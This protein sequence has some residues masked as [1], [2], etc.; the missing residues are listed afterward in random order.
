MRAGAFEGSDAAGGSGWSNGWWN[1]LV[2]ADINGDGYPD[3]VAGNHGLNSRFRVSATKPVSM[4]VSDFD[5][6]GST[7]QIVCCY[8]GRRAIRWY[9][10]T[11]WWD[12][13]PT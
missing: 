12:S 13:Y 7:E 8:N 1:R 5:G 10:V 3:I 9:C 4:Y 6:N 11:T 2:I